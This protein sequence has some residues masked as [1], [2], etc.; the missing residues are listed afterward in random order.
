MKARIGSRRGSYW[1]YRQRGLGP[2]HS[3]VTLQWKYGTKCR[4]GLIRFDAV[5]IFGDAYKT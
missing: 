1:Q 3:Y 5:A 2:R 4:G